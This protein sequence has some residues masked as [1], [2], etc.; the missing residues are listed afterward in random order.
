MKPGYG[1]ISRYGLI[2]YASSFDQIGIFAKAIEDVAVTLQVIAGE[3]EFDSTV[4]TIP[5][6]DYPDALNSNGK[7][8]GL[9]ISGRHLITR[10]L[11]VKL[12][13]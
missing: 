8:T 9:L 1:K 2:A 3:D 12:Q 7:N 5:L 10:V 6:P 11:T 4:S 13:P